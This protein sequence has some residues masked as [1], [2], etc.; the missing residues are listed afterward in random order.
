[1]FERK[2][3][4]LRATGVLLAGLIAI[5]VW[6]GRPDNVL[7]ITVMDVGQ[8]D[9]ILITTPGGNDILIDGGPDSRTVEALRRNLPPSDNELELV[10]L[11]HP[12]LD[13][14]GG[15]P[16]VADRYRIDR[17]LETSVRSPGIAD[18]RWE[19]AIDQQASERLVA[20][21]GDVLHVDHVTL[22]I[23]W[24]TKDTDLTKLNRNDTSIVVL[25]EYGSSSFLLSGD[26]EAGVEE[27]LL[28]LGE[29]RDVDVL[30]VPHHGSITSSTDAFLDTV[31]PE[32]AVISDGR[33]N[34]FGHP[35]PVVLRRLVGRGVK[36]LRTDEAGDVVMKSDGAR[37]TVDD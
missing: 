8:G 9:A 13:H 27:R 18:Q 34:K 5:F 2:F 33:N 4:V 37:V 21:S 11:T 29:L 3:I 15:L 14:V 23:L 22:T 17:V 19:R 31:K 36:V 12:D 16:D 35:H 7:R 10:V 30:K 20:F 26:I 6:T 32:I 25:L 1:M 28:Q 24:P